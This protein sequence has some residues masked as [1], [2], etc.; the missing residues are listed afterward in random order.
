MRYFRIH[1]LGD[2]NSPRHVFLDREPEEL[3][4][5][6]FC[7]GLGDR[8]GAHYPSGAKMYLQPESPGLELTDLLG[9]CLTYLVVSSR[10]KGAI[11]SCANVEIEYLP[12]AIYNHR[13]RLHSDDYWIIN[14]IGTIDCVDEHNSDVVRGDLTGEIVDVLEFAFVAERLAPPLLS[15]ADPSLFRVKHAPAEYFI[16]EAT[17]RSIHALGCSNVLVDEVPCFYG[18]EPGTF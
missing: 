13:N 5:W 14:P 8:I 1:I 4:G 18:C 2:P 6:G 3:D 16:N 11:E 10:M 17:A 15:V 12:V 9:N 7:M